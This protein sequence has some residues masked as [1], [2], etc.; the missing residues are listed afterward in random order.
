M[1]NGRINRIPD[2]A[3]LS[4]LFCS[5]MLFALATDRIGVHAIFGAFLL[6]V[7]TPR[8]SSHITRAAGRLRAINEILLPLFFVYSGLRTDIGLLA[9]SWHEWAWCVLII[10]VAII[11]KWGSTTAAAW[12][13]GVTW[14]DA[15]S[16]G[17]LMNCRGLTELIVLNVGLDLGIISRTVFTMLVIMA[18]ISTI[19][20]SPA[21][22]AITR[23]TRAVASAQVTGHN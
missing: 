23:L 5:I 8:G 2:A 16:L 18:L 20:T 19:I 22:S 9:A 7:V 4:I 1:R 17:A 10:V 21:I 11:A 14:P 15:L 12:A 3:L 6:G 13:T